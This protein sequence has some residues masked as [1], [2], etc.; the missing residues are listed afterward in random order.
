MRDRQWNFLLNAK[1]DRRFGDDGSSQSK[2]GIAMVVRR[3]S[4][5]SRAAPMPRGA[6][7]LRDPLLNKGTAFTEREREAFGLRGLLPGHPAKIEFP[8]GNR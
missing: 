8:H 6:A 7:L 5:G 1:P 3:K 4:S 2:E